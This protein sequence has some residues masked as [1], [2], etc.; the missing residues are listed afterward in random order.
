MAEP[1]TVNLP[2][3]SPSKASP[4]PEELSG[5]SAPDS[6]VIVQTGAGSCS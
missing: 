2:L 5:T 4:L 1:I 3:L 6:L